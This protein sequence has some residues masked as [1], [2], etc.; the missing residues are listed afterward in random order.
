MF[1]VYKDLS[2]EG[3]R[4]HSTVHMSGSGT[5]VT[6]FTWVAVAL[7]LHCLHEW[8]LH[9]RYTVYMSGSGTT[10]TLFT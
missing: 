8:Q 1:K 2:T 7:P 3:F 5:T 10:V 9:Y 4:Q 6:L